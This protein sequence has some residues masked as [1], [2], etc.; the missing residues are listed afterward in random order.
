MNQRTELLAAAEAR[1]I[2]DNRGELYVL[3]SCFLSVC[4]LFFFGFFVPTK[5]LTPRGFQA[6]AE[7]DPGAGRRRYG[8]LPNGPATANATVNSLPRLAVLSFSTLNHDF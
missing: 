2:V 8:F 6:W 1:G 4:F 5:Q 3:F 7:A